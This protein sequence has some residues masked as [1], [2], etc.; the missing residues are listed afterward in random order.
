MAPSTLIFRNKY[1][2]VSVVGQSFRSKVGDHQ[3]AKTIK[4]NSNC[5]DHHI[6]VVISYLYSI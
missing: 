4:N 2:V 3:M 5:K 1:A 6:T